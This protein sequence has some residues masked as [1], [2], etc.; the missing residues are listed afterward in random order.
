MSMERNWCIA[1]V[2]DILG[3]KEE[4]NA[5]IKKEEI[6]YGKKLKETIHTAIR[7]VPEIIFDA[8]ILSDTIILTTKLNDNKKNISIKKLFETIRSTYLQ[9]LKQNILIRGGV[10]YGPHYCEDA[11]SYSSPIINAHLIEK[12]VAIFPRIVLSDNFIQLLKTA[13]I[14]EFNYII[15][16]ELIF[17]QNGVRFLNILTEDNWATV[18]NC[19]R[20]LYINC[21]TKKP[22]ELSKSEPAR[23]KLDYYIMSQKEKTFLKHL[24]F[25]NYILSYHNKYK[26]EERYIISKCGDF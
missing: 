9:F 3:F 10:D 13:Y 11:F 21:C 20:Q 7:D 2:L 1:I 8:Q 12:H 4:F 26:T 16:E 17:E 14:G 22:L 18:Y 24:W 15:E 5:D 6:I 19:A 23:T 25:E